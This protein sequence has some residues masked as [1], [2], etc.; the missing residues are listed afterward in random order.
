M[1][2]VTNFTGL[3]FFFPGNNNAQGLVHVS[4]VLYQ[5]AL[6]YTSKT[7]DTATQPYHTAFASSSHIYNVR[8]SSAPLPIAT[9]P[10]QHQHSLQ[11]SF[12]LTESSLQE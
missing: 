8:L 12:F 2:N 3:L 6:A 7:T 4:Q 10:A 5:Q 9:H 11:T 1:K